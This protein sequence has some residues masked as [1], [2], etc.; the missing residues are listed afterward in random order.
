MQ[1]IKHFL[2]L[3]AAIALTTV[4]NAQV[5]NGDLNH[6]GKLEV[7]D[8]TRLIS[9]YLAG[10]AETVNGGGDPFATDNSLVVGTWYKSPKESITFRS[11]GTTDYATGCTYKFLPFQ[12]RII[13][14]NADGI[15]V[16]SLKVPYI[17]KDYI[18][19]L[20]T[21]SDDFVVYSSTQPI[22]I[23][24]TLSQ[25]SLEMKPDEFTRLTATVV[26]SDAGTVTWTSSNESVATVVSGFVTAVADGTAIITASVGNASATCTVTVASK[27]MNNGHEYVDLGLSVKWAT[28]NIGASSPEDYGDYFAWGETTTKSTCD[29]STYKWC[30]GSYNTMTKYCTSSDYGTVDNKTVL[31]LADDAANA[32]WGGNWRMP[33]NAEQ[34][35]L[36]NNCTWTWTTQNGVNGYKVTSKTNGNSLFFPAAGYW[37]TSLNHAGS[38]GRYWSRSL[39]TSYSYSAWDMYFDSSGVDT[40]SYG[41]YYGRSVR[42]VCP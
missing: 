31:D 38:Y 1:R 2:L 12:G 8:V 3:L 37:G 14:F 4:A 6:S 17:T 42:P 39:S 30:K 35:E 24:I 41:R 23:S 22:S 29:W 28:M 15:P 11:N 40:S 27:P 20:P 36:R 7:S 13:F 9:N 10:T 25:T 16:T 18:A 26:P 34:D 21:G 19:V 33:T 32:N 5:I